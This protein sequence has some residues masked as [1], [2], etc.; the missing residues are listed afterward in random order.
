MMKSPASLKFA[1]L[2]NGGASRSNPSIPPDPDPA[3]RRQDHSVCP[4]PSG[5]VCLNACQKLRRGNGSIGM[6]MTSILVNIPGTKIRRGLEFGERAHCRRYPNSG[7]L[8]GSQERVG[9]QDFCIDANLS[10][11]TLSLRAPDVSGIRAM[12]C[13]YERRIYP[14]LAGLS[15]W[16][17]CVL[18]F[19][20]RTSL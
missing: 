17:L 16:D 4:G 10:D 12:T 8:E 13:V 14:D 11:L 7:V 15:L 18:L 19:L 2:R 3:P 9:I 20:N 1:V 5:P 6:L